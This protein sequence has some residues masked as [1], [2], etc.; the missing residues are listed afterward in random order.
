MTRKKDW[1]KG[2]VYHVTVRDDLRNPGEK[3]FPPRVSCE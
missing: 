2:V 1:Y 3:V